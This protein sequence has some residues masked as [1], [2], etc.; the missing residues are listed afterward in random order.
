MGGYGYWAE[1]IL[2]HGLSMLQKYQLVTS[3]KLVFE[4]PKTL[5]N[6]RL[7]AEWFRM[8]TFVCN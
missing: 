7:C 3:L 4:F 1:C 6:F 2:G 5:A 8:L